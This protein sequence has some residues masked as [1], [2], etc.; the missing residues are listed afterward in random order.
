MQAASCR[1][2]SPEAPDSVLQTALAP[3]SMVKV[4]CGADCEWAPAAGAVMLICVDLSTVKFVDAGVESERP[5]VSTARAVS[6]CALPSE[7]GLRFTVQLKPSPGVV[8]WPTK[9]PS[10]ENSTR[11]TPALSLG[12]AVKVLTFGPTTAGGDEKAVLGSVVSIQVICTRVSSVHLDLAFRRLGV[13]SQ[14]KRVESRHVPVG[15]A[16]H[17]LQDGEKPPGPPLATSVM[18]STSSP[19]LHVPSSQVRV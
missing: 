4:N 19:L 13:A 5:D 9:T 18:V 12:D 7:Y 2:V 14:R 8:S 16:R 6:V 10:I 1:L 15:F 11:A 17:R 3:A